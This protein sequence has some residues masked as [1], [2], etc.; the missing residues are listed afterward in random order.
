MKR[1]NLSGQNNRRSSLNNRHNDPF[2]FD[3]EPPARSFSNREGRANFENKPPARKRNADN[4]SGF[5]YDLNSFDSG[6]RE[7]RP[8]QQPERSQQRRRSEAQQ[9]EMP[10]QRGKQQA[11]KPESRTASRQAPKNRE[12]SVQ[13]QNKEEMRRAQYIRRK[14]RQKRNKVVGMILLALIVTLTTV[15][16]SLTVFFKISDISIVDNKLYSQDQILR[17][18]DFKVNDNMFMIG[19]SKQETNIANKLPYIKSAKITYKLPS[20]V[21]ITVTET[22]AKYCYKVDES[23]YLLDEDL[24]VLEGNVTQLPEGVAEIQEVTFK[25]FEISKKAV[26]ANEKTA[27]QMN[28]LVEALKKTELDKITAVKPVNESTNFVVY[29]GRINIKLGS[30]TKLDYKLTLAKAGIDKENEKSPGAKGTLDVTVDK[31]ARFTAEQ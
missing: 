16:L 23:Y 11:R 30:L 4:N 1:E 2:D 18:I 6:R 10:P 17:M 25:P 21:V 12:E 24:I 5:E 28:A 26:V 8:L 7:K 22:T 31:Q 20:T 15:V 27:K 19:K 29:D 14:R 9:P 3:L 13:Y